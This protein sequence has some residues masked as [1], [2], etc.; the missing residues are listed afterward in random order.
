MPSSLPEFERPPIDEV[1][2]GVQ[3]E[4]L[5]QYH[6]AHAGL[7]WSRIRNR[8][9]FA[10]DQPPLAP[11][12]ESPDPQPARQGITIQPGLTIVR[13]W[14]LDDK[15]TQLIQLQRDRFIRNWRQLQGDETYP[16]FGYL[17]QEFR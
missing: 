9:P 5:Q 13:N 4:A 6:V 17:I 10:E 15:K 8:Y 1:A 7:F 2:I 3:F 14:F 12:V 11:Q 16:R